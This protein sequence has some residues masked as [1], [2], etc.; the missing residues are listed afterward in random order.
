MFNIGY[1]GVFSLYGCIFC[2]VEVL[3]STKSGYQ[4]F[5]GCIILVISLP[6]KIGV[7]LNNYGMPLLGTEDYALVGY[8]GGMRAE[9]GG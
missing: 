6:L 2:I 7:L 3:R 4:S 8:W 5:F 9:S 1:T